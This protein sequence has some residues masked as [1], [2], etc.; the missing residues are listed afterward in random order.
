MAVAT[1]YTIWSEREGS[2]TVAAVHALVHICCLPGLEAQ[3]VRRRLRTFLV[4]V[5]IEITSNECPKCRISYVARAIE[6]R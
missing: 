4:Q 1:A 5:Q 2:E 3:A 6:S